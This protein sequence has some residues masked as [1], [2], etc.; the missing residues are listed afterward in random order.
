[1]S[2]D[3][4]AEV[5]RYINEALNYSDFERQLN[6]EKSGIFLG[7]Y[8]INPANRQKIPVWVS[9]Y[10]LMNYGTGAVMAVPSHD[11]RDFEFA[12]K[13]N[14]P[15]KPVIS[16]DKNL[17]EIPEPYE[18]EGIMINSG[19]FNG[20]PSKKAKEKIAFYVG[21]KKA[22]YY[23]LRDWIFSRQ[24]YWGEPIPIIKC[25]KCG[26]V[27][28]KEKDLPLKLP[29]LEK[30][31]PTGKNESPL[32]DIVSWV[33]VQCPKCG[34]PAKRETN[35]MPQWAGSCWYYLRYLD[36][37]NKKFLVD[38]KKQKTWLPVNLYIGGVEHAVLHL[39]YARFWHKFLY[40]LGI[41]SSKEPFFKLINQ[42]TILGEDGE[43]MSKSRG[44]VVSPD[45]VIKKYGADALR[46]Y[47]MFLGPLT[48]AKSWQTNG[49]IGVYRF[50]NRVWDLVTGSVLAKK[51][52]KSEKIK[53]TK[54]SQEK[55]KEL[56][57]H[58]EITRQ[59]TIKKVTED[60]EHFRFNTAISTLMEYLNHLEEIPK[61]KI[62][63]KHLETLILLLSPFAPHLCEELASS[64]LGFKKPLLKTKW[65]TYK[66]D[67]LKENQIVIVVQVNG[68]TRAT[69]KVKKGL[70]QKEIE[71]QS[72]PLIKKY[73]NQKIK[74]IVFVPDKIINFVF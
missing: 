34:G 10:V 73:L 25:E 70:S 57:N 19:P 1:V 30:F 45:E 62:D 16:P 13:F 71:K 69:L 4:K 21:G 47:E 18:G 48:S 23:K 9:D 41:V 63:K 12:K 72:L 42:G 17:K 60:I 68:K 49:V 26:N 52:K 28:L 39:L 38:F 44:N 53:M 58:L 37:K 66:P 2:Q 56:I 24:R 11:K 54:E 8:A 32:A 29:P 55:L 5:E 36:P 3:R 65:P 67:V 7:I 33:N 50:L 64:Y 6:K 46:M 27:P 35:T 74:R 59:R 40:D 43:K 15:T 14:L 51:E 20:L 22:V 61:E 31:Q